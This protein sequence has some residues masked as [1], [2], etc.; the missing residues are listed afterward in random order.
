M[1][2]FEWGGGYDI[3][4]GMYHV[5]FEDPKRER[6]KKLSGT[7]YNNVITSKKV[8]GFARDRTY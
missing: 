1:D 6:R 8:I 5:D 7:F 3:R 2:N 4:F